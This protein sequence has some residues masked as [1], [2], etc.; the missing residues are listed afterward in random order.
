MTKNRILLVL[1][2][3]IF[4]YAIF[5]VRGIDRQEEQATIFVEPETPL[6]EPEVLSAEIVS[7]EEG[8]KDSRAESLRVFLKRYNSPI[9]G[10]E[11]Y[12][13]KK[14]DEYQVDYKL[15]VALACTESSCWKKCLSKWNCWGWGATDSEYRLGNL[16]WSTF[17]NGLETFLKGYSRRYQ[18][19]ASVKCLKERGYNSHDVWYNNMNLFMRELR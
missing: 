18:D 10:K 17:E 7:V 3:L 1:G 13:L 4:S 19:C 9:Q 12:L 6:E 2:T 16:D 5:S 14:C 8:E 15:V 11:E